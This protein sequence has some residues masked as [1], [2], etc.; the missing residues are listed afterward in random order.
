MIG[1]VN[2]VGAVSTAREQAK[3][4]D[5]KIVSGSNEAG[6]PPMWVRPYGANSEADSSRA[7]SP[8]EFDRFE[9]PRPTPEGEGSD[10]FEQADR[11]AAPSS[12]LGE[13]ID[14]LA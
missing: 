1:L 2:A 5:Q 7:V 10:R 13:R 8:A 11:D 14:T 4:T 12:G 3:Q 6:A 9:Q